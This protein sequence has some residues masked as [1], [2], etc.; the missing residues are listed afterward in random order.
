MRKHPDDEGEFVNDFEEKYGQHKRMAAG[1]AGGQEVLTVRQEASELFNIV[2]TNKTV[3]PDTVAD[4]TKQK[5]ILANLLR[6]AREQSIGLAREME[7]LIQG[8]IEG[9]LKPEVFTSKL[10]Q[11]LGPSRPPPG[12]SLKEFWLYLQKLKLQVDSGNEIK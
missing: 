8:F 6:L 7:N 2:G 4:K 11:E 3:T 12:P 5:N 9:K 1:T 10:Q